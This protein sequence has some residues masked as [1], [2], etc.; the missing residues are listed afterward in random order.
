MYEEVDHAFHND[1]NPSP[2]DEDGAKLA[3]ERSDQS[4]TTSRTVPV[5][6][7]EESRAK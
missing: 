3:W 6:L 5:P 7:A 2:Y 4:T 1:T